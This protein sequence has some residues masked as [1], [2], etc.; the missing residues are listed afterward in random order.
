MTTPAAEQDLLTIEHRD[1]GIVCLALNRPDK[2]N[3][4]NDALVAAIERFFAAPP[5]GARVVVLHGLGGHFCAGLDLHE[6]LATRTPDPIRATRR[7]RTW[8]R[9]FDLVQYG[10]LPVVSVLKGGV[11]GGGLELAAA[12]HVRVAEDSTFFQLP[13]GQRGIF[14]GG[15]GSVR[16]PRI[17]GAGR[18]TEMMLT[19]RC[20]DA[21]TGLAL[22]LAHERVPDG[23]GLD[24]A[25]ELARAI[26]SNAPASNYAVING[27]GRIAEMGMAEGLFAETLVTGL[28]RGAGQSAER[29]QAFFEG[30][31]QSRGG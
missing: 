20:Y 16:I 6:L 23:Q 18:V 27:I 31:R 19:G 1:D 10:E 22:G 3:A 29:I 8:H 12:T 17:I 30:R 7:S 4:L 15:G 9:V 24:K 28:T 5:D 26:A 25:L 11:I 14:L 21:D 2:R 13:E